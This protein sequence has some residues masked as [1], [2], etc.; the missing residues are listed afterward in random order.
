M[1]LHTFTFLYQRL[2]SRF[3]IYNDATEIST[4]PTIHVIIII[5]WLEQQLAIT[6]IADDVA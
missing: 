3:C 1:L 2:L 4:A 5:T 6:R